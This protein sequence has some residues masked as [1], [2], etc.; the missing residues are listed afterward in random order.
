ML[1]FVE[2][3]R[4]KNVKANNGR[5]GKLFVAEKRFEKPDFESGFGGSGGE[6]KFFEK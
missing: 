2:I 1:K 4:R 5:V 6:T 3:I